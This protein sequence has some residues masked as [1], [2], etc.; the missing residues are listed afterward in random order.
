MPL[1]M[2][3]FY[4]A[5]ATMQGQFFANLFRTAKINAQN[6]LIARQRLQRVLNCTYVFAQSR[7]Y[8]SLFL[9]VADNISKELHIQD[10]PHSVDFLFSRVMEE[11]A[12]HPDE[13]I[14]HFTYAAPIPGMPGRLSEVVSA[15]E[16]STDFSLNEEDKLT[17]LPGVL[18]AQTGEYSAVPTSTLTVPID[19]GFFYGAVVVRRYAQVGFSAFE[20]DLYIEFVNSIAASLAVT[21]KNIDYLSEV[22]KKVAMDSQLDAARAQQNALLAQAPEVENLAYSAFS[23]SAGKTGGDWHGCYFDKSHRRLFVTVGDV[24]GHDFASSILTGV[25]AG[26]V[27]AWEV[28]DSRKFN[29][30]EDALVEL[31]DVVNRVICSSSQG[32]K[33][34]T[35]IFVCLEIDTG[36][37]HLVNAGHAHPFY[38]TSDQKPASIAV[39]GHILGQSV[40]SVYKP[41]KLQLR[42]GDALVLFTDGL[43]ENENSSGEKLQRRKFINY[44]KDH[45]EKEDLFEGFVKLLDETWGD[46]ELEDDVTVV[47]V[48]WK[49]PNAST[50]SVA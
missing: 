41:E 7:D 15:Q 20:K 33:F 28:N 18:S 35:M 23:R 19:F 50:A 37:C 29:S 36:V 44:W 26:A 38:L 14:T 47:T 31:A 24:T 4:L 9:A 10:E 46:F 5:L 16:N 21:L 17:S 45:N 48:G 34:M 25:A 2:L 1:G 43:F 12:H 11:G 42:D 30:A 13:K 39:S 6:E 49:R 40:N 3:A 27:R 22:K 8:K 32:L